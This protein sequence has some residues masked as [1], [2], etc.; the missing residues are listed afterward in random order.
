M[1]DNEPIVHP[2]V[3]NT[4]ETRKRKVE[5]RNFDIR[6]HM[7]EYDDVM[8]EQ[9][10]T[11][12]KL[13]QQLLVGAYKP[14]RVD[15]EGKPLGRVRDIAV[16]PRIAEEV[17]QAIIDIVIHHGTPLDAA[18][19]ADGAPSEALRAPKSIEEISEIYSMASLQQDVYQIWGYR[20][21]FKEG[22]GKK[23]Q[24]VYE[25]LREEIPRSLSEQREQLLDLVDTIVG[26]IV[27][28]C[29]PENKPPEDWDWKG[30]RTGFIE[31]F[32]VRPP[33]VE[34]KHD[35][36]QV[37]KVLYDAA[38]ARLEEREKDMG[39]ELFLRVF[40]H[41]YLE[42]IDKQWVEHLTD[43]EHLRDGIG[44]R[45]YGQRDPKQEYK[46][47]GYDIFIS[48]MATI[49]S[50]VCS[51]LFKVRVQRE[52]SE[53]ERMERADA[54]RRA[55]Q[56]R[57]MQAR[58]GSEPLAADEEAANATARAARPQPRVS[59]QPI[60]RDS[61]KIGRND[62]CPCGSGLKFKKCHGAALDDSDGSDND[63]PAA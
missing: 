14:E 58:H 6:K 43:M 31:H 29:C 37:A 45:G 60:R 61:P 32:V 7:L 51:N 23:P 22:D 27:E 8:N 21:E 57:A 38:V 26:A 30:I 34:T 53:V 12:Y 47:E 40:R 46:K 35:A 41:F 16:D 63:A 54:E 33:D 28:E 49:S 44:L 9:R 11:V 2:W 19:A 15:E 20:F 39:T 36:E 55:A 48:M 62:P 1:P 18:P 50:T 52:R 10:K 25:R 13:R 59:V 5:E 4:I 42:E 3:T 56:Q 24:S 17:K